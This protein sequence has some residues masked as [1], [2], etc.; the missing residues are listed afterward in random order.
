MLVKL[1]IF[2]QNAESPWRYGQPALLTVGL[3]STGST[4]RAHTQP[5]VEYKCALRKSHDTNELVYQCALGKS[6][7]PRSVPEVSHNRPKKISENEGK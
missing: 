1:Y 7:C 5:T 2:R 4:G 3:P 6:G